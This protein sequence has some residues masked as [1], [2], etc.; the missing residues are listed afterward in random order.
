MEYIKIS[1][2]NKVATVEGAPRIICGN[3]DYVISFTFDEEW[4][5]IEDKIARFVFLQNGAKKYIDVKIKGNTCTAPMLTNIERVKIGVYAENLATTTGAEVRCKKSILCGSGEGI[6]F[7]ASVEYSSISY[8]DD[9]TITLIDTDGNEHTIVCE[10]DGDKLVSATYDDKAIDLTY[11]GEALVGVDGA[12]VDLSN[13]KVSGGS[14]SYPP[15]WFTFEA[16][17]EP[18]GSVERID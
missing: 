12:S 6:V 7:D 16:N 17:V 11:E 4:R 15:T 8:N 5:G 2:L 9:D 3:S 14:I 1:V 10:Y 13:A 18:T